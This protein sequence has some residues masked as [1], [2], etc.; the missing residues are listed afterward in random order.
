MD[1]Q[2]RKRWQDLISGVK[3]SWEWEGKTVFQFFRGMRLMWEQPV[4]L[5]GKRRGNE[6]FQA[7][8]EK[9][10]RPPLNSTY[11]GTWLRNVSRW[12]LVSVLWIFAVALHVGIQAVISFIPLPLYIYLL[13][14]MSEEAKEKNTKPAHRKKKGKKVIPC[15]DRLQQCLDFWGHFVVLAVCSW[16]WSSFGLIICLE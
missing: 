9:K 13:W 1:D 11:S 15:T 4:P 10:Q 2:A 8:Q 12:T 7:E 3:P 6:Q 14:K 16:V 5:W